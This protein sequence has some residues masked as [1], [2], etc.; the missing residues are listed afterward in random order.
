MEWIGKVEQ[1]DDLGWMYKSEK[2]IQ[3]NTE[4]DHL[5]WPS[6]SF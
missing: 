2:A 6:D 5:I 1:E 4:K 3:F